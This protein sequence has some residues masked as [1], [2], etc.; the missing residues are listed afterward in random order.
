MPSAGPVKLAVVSLGCAKN[1][2]DTERALGQMVSDSLVLVDDFLQADWVLV[3]T[4]GFIEEAK[5]ES[6]ETVLEIAELKKENPHLKIAVAGCLS[7]RYAD[8]LPAELP[9]ADA[10]VGIL[11]RAN[12]ARLLQRITGH[13]GACPYGED[14]DRRRLRITPGHFAYLRVSEGCDNRCAYCAIPDIRGPLRSRPLENV[15]ADAEELVSDG[16]VELNIIAQDTTSYGIDLYGAPR[17]GEL[18]GELAHINPH[19]WLRLLYAHPAHISGDV[20]DALEKGY[21]IVPYLD[22]PLQHIN[23]FVLARMG[24][25]VTKG[26]VRDI[27]SAVRRRVPGVHI[28]TTFIVGFPGEGEDEFA[29]LMDFIRET[30]FERLGAFAYSREEG[31]RASEMTGQVDE[32]EKL[33][34]LDILMETQREIAYDFNRSLVGKRL[35]GIIDGPSGRDD[36]PLAGR[37]Y[38]DAPEVDGTVLASGQAAAGELVEFEITGTEDYDLTA[39]VRR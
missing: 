17:L 9:E 3:N 11:T 23:D 34:R 22:L 25:G 26:Q 31:T 24:R 27:I 20:I 6:I 13:A 5:S 21:P 7:Q 10:V 2:V 30:R 28:R 1:L 12:A 38:G 33:R 16:A 14:T 29:E 37:T 32:D 39:E 18:L 36:L 4:C 15:L 35:R 8:S 19:G